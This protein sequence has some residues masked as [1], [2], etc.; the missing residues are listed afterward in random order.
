[1]G[2]A[3]LSS[4]DSDPQ[5][6]PPVRMADLATLGF[7]FFAVGVTVS[8]ALVG[9]GGVS[10]GIRAMQ[11]LKPVLATVKLRLV[12]E[13]PIP[14]VHERRADDGSIEA[15]DPMREG[16]GAALDALAAEVRLLDAARQATG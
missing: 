4:E 7:T 3:V 15:N 9:Y 5:E 10:G 8:V 11:S 12:A 14:F 13:V 2:P 16:A 1:M 6:A